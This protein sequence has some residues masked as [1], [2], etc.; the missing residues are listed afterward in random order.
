VVELSMFS[1]P[2]MMRAAKMETMNAL[3][4]LILQKENG[5]GRT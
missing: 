1:N 5:S 3:S 4:E 2:K